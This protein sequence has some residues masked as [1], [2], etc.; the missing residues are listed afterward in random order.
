MLVSFG[1]TNFFAVVASEQSFPDLSDFS[2]YMAL[3]GIEQKGSRVN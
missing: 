2:K 3:H 1:K